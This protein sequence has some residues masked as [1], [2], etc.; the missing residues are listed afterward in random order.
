MSHCKDL[1]GGGGIPNHVPF[2]LKAM[3]SMRDNHAN[4]TV[5]D[6]KWGV[7]RTI[8]TYTY[9]PYVIC[10]ATLGCYTLL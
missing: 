9:F 7:K 5:D 6:E 2:L 3:Q 10:K 4:V 1:D 8:H